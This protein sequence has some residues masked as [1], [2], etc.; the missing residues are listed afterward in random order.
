MTQT[1]EGLYSQISLSGGA[2]RDKALWGEHY[3]GVDTVENL[4]ACV[5]ERLRLLDTYYGAQEESTATQ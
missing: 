5:S 1:I 2:A 3:G 4:I